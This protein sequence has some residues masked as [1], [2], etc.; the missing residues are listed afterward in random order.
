M[1][2]T[3]GVD[4]GGTKVLAGVVDEHG[5]ILA[6]SRRPTPSTS[7]TET[8]DAIAAAVSELRQGHDI[9]A[10]GIGAA[11]WIDETRSRVLFA[12]NLAWRE[13]PL[14]DIVEARIGLPV[15]VENDAN[16]AA[17]GEYR[18]GAGRGQGHLIL[19]T[20]GTGIGC[21]I[22]L[23]GQLYRGRFGVGGEPG[24]VRVVPDGR[25]CGCG[26]RGCWEQYCSGRALEREAREIVGSS[27]V[28]GA[29]LLERAGGDI[30]KITGPLVTT[31]AL[32]GEP[33]ALECF[34]IVGGWLGQGLADLAATLDPGCF[35]IGGGVSEA[36]ELLLAPARAM[37][38]ATLTGRGHRPF[39]EIVVAGLSQLAGLVGA[40]DL[41]RYRD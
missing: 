16:A 25:R 10:V 2:L 27:A 13:E 9:E 38:A 18:F 12:P 26:N 37:Y 22:I 36:G 29:D 3:I 30:D 23:D 28:I 33:V 31:A 14:R 17:W 5:A 7:P 40:A 8:A 4:V 41:A 6:Q 15:I 39:A 34:N 11:G 21:G 24:H 35:V 20:V 1:G 32:E 19:I